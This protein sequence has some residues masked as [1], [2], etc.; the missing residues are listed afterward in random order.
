MGVSAP[1]IRRAEIVEAE[2]RLVAEAE[3]TGDPRGVLSFQWY[4]N[5]RP[6][7]RD[8][9][10]TA[11]AVPAYCEVM[12]DNGEGYAISATLPWQPESITEPGNR[13]FGPSFDASFG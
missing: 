9:F 5:G 11:P 3:W 12:V 10:I 1:T 6:G 8:A 4:L 2:S 13:A 7:A